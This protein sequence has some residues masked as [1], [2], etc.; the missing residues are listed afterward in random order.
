MSF[1]TTTALSVMEAFQ[2]SGIPEAIQNNNGSQILLSWRVA[3]RRSIIS[4]ALISKMSRMARSP[5]E[6][7]TH[8][9]TGIAPLSGLLALSFQWRR[10]R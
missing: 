10:M 6:Q 7:E 3:I 2:S 5:G 9:L 8:Q 4:L 1:W